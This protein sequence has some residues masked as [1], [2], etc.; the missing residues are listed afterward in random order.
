M[1]G[2][3][4]MVKEE[5]EES[6]QV[7]LIIALPK[8]P[9]RGLPLF[10]AAESVGEDP[11]VSSSASDE[12]ANDTGAVRSSS[13][14]SSTPEGTADVR[15][16]LR[17]PSA[18]DRLAF[19]SFFADRFSTTSSSSSTGGGVSPG[20]TMLATGLPTALGREGLDFFVGLEDL[21]E[22]I[23]VMPGKERRFSVSS[24]LK[25]PSISIGAGARLFVAE[26]RDG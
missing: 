9:R 22:D 24:S 23:S 21:A 3:I 15:V 11:S 25:S 1:A 17:N 5:E 13:S 6:L 18:R 2:A 10:S 12:E 20:V 14:S 4:S 19:P 16:A 7:G 26:E 8:A